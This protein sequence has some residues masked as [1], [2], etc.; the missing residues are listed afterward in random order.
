MCDEE[1]ADEG[2]DGGPGCPACGDE[3]VGAAA[4]FGVEMFRD[5]FAV[6]R[7]RDRFTDTEQKSRAQKHREA[8]RQ[9][10]A[11]RGE[12]PDQY[13]D[14]E[15]TVDVEAIDEPSREDL[16]EGICPEKGRE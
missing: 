1:S 10:G 9:A 12:R 6:G 3:S 16:A 4:M 13:A 15:D 5:D 2:A 8:A 14:R 7:I 11:E